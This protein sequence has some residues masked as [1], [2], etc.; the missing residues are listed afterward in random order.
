MGFVKQRQHLQ[1]ATSVQMRG[2]V[3]ETEKAQRAHCIARIDGLRD[4]VSA[5]ERS[6]SVA[7]LVAVFYVVVNERIV[8]KNLYRHRRIECLFHRRSF[9]GGHPHHHLRSKPF[10]SSRRSVRSVTKVTQKHIG[11]LFRSPISGNPFFEGALKALGIINE[12]KQ[13][14]PAP[15]CASQRDQPASPAS[16]RRTSGRRPRHRRTIAPAARRALRCDRRARHATPTSRQ[17]V[18]C[19]QRSCRP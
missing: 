17:D 8:V 4:A 7:Q 15:P 10:A 5:P 18:W 19:S 11:D 14:P 3:F 12:V 9:A 2:R 13:T 16:T 1:D 6:A